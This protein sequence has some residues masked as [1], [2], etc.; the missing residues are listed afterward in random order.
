MDSVNFDGVDVST[1][2]VA[3]SI[4]E[5]LNSLAVGQ[6][7][8]FTASVT[9]TANTGVTWS[10]SP[11]GQGSINPSTGIYTAPASVA[12]PSLQTVTVTA[13]SVADPA[14]SASVIVILG[15]F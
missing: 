3:V 5:G 2:P 1:S 15:G 6:V 13:T 10:I 7:A 8:Q 12:S 9:G 4:N 14:R 11:A